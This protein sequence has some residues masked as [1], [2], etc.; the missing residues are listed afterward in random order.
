MSVH[1][2]HHCAQEIPRAKFF[3]I[4]QPLQP[5]SVINSLTI[6]MSIASVQ[7]YLIRRAWKAG[8]APNNF[9]W[10][11]DSIQE[12]LCG[13]VAT[14][15]HYAL[16]VFQYFYL[17]IC[18]C[19]GFACKV[20]RGFVIEFVGLEGGD[21][22]K[23]DDLTV[24]LQPRSRHD[25]LVVT[26]LIWFQFWPI[27][28][29]SRLCP[30]HTASPLQGLS[31]QED[32]ASTAASCKSVILNIE[33]L[34][35]LPPFSLPLSLHLPHSPCCPLCPFLPPPSLSLSPLFQLL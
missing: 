26:K 19:T 9:V 4:F 11:L 24:A 29:C 2:G 22:E 28:I 27:R 7:T 13:W 18:R 25:L 1:L 14:Q 21:T 17:V 32:M 34:S 20:L 15:F 30:L 12:C 8:N 31:H 33:S 3:C 10:K 35:L 6:T 5:S 23:I 16:V